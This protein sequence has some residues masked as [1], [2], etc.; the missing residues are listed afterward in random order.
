MTGVLLL[1]EMIQSGLL[2]PWLVNGPRLNEETVRLGSWS[3]YPSTGHMS[4]E[5]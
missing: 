5:R 4:T 1:W 2:N 3:P